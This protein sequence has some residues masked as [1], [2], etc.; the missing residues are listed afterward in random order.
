MNRC[1]KLAVL[2]STLGLHALLHADVINLTDGSILEG[3]LIGRD[4]GVVMFRVDGAIRA[5]PEAQVAA[6]VETDDSASSG[7]NAVAAQATAPATAAAPVT[8]AT[9]PAGTTLTLSL[10]DSV[11]SR[12]HSVG[13]KFKAQLESALTVNGVTVL[14]RGTQLMGVVTEQSQA[15]RASGQS[16]L[17][18]E[19]TDIMINNQFFP[20][21]TSEISQQG[22][23]EGRETV[24]RAARGAVIGGLIDGSD[25]ARDG[26][27]I[28]AGVSILT[29]SESINLPRGTILETR[30]ST[31][32][33]VQQ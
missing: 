27:A 30:L 17:A 24:R 16:Q 10:L 7:S 4:N 3:E 31:P 25:G 33:M 1:A 12:Q 2:I 6:L 5:F 15:R 32:V 23:P 19:F 29:P 26:A 20:I 21:A 14:P 9:I 11:D 28:G 18:I 8:T 22:A 13:Y